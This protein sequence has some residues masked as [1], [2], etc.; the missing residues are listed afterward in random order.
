MKILGLDFETTSL[1][2]RKARIIEAGAV[3]FEVE[4]KHWHPV[5]DYSSFVWDEGD[6]DLGP[7]TTKITGIT[8][9]MVKTGTG[10]KTVLEVLADYA[11]KCDMVIAHNANYDKGVLKEVVER[12]IF[13]LIPGVQSLLAMD[14]LCSLVD[15][16]Q[17]KEYKCKKLSHL[18][19][20]LG[21]PVNPKDL[22]R[23]AGDVT[24]MGKMLTAAKADPK[25]MLKYK[26]TPEIFVQGKVVPPWEDQGKSKN[27]ATKAG[28]GWQVARGTEG[29]EF[30]KTWVIKIKEDEIEDL[31]K[32]VSFDVKIIPMAT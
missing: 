22:H 27:E 21:V 19:L 23:A 16:K 11:D 28:F 25:E 31:R 26:R 3:I 12:G 1:D 20:D 32:S 17:I 6:A 29:P 24:L 4:D 7:E 14:W 15:L 18:A 9:D 30:P 5:A 13:G 10:I 8:T 2:I